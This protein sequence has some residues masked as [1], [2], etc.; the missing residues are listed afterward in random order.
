MKIIKPLVFVGIC[1]ILGGCFAEAMDTLF[2][3][4]TPDNP[5]P[6]G[7]DILSAFGPV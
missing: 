2:G 3:P 6:A 7:D 4:A 1:F 5:N